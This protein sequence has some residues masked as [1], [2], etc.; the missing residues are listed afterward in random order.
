[1]E[2]KH[3]YKNIIKAISLFGGVK[4]FQILVG[5][6]KNKVVAVILG[7]SGMGIVGM[8]TSTTSMI[9]AL[10]GF[11]LETSAVRDVS[12]AYT[13]NNEESVNKVITVLRKLILITGILGM[14]ITFI[15]SSYLSVWAFGNTDYSLSFKIVS[16][17]LL[18]NQLSIGQ[19]V[20]LQGTFHYKYMAKA[21]FI[22]SILGLII[23]VPLYYIYEYQAIVPVIIVTALLNLILTWF[24]S[25]KIQFVPIKMSFSQ[26]FFEGKSMLI[27]GGA[28]ALTGLI[29][30][31]QVY[32]F[33]ILISNYGGM[34]D[35][36]LYTAGITIATSYIGI[37]LNAMGSD[38]SPR[39]ASVA[40]E[41]PL[42]IQT[43]NR[44]ALLL[45]IILAP[46]IMVFVVF[47]K[48]FVILLYSNKFV[49]ISDMIIWM[50]FGMFFRAISWSISYSFVAVN[51]PKLFLW[52]EII[53]TLYSLAFSIL[54]YL[55]Y[56]FTG[57]GIAF[58]LTYVLYSFHMY[59]L[60]KSKFGFYFNIDIIKKG[61]P[62]LIISSV[63]FFILL[64]IHNNVL[65]YVFGGISILI[66]S[67]YSLKNL[68]KLIDLRLQLNSLRKKINKSTNE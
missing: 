55:W 19:T 56:R 48:E 30:T 67:F 49:D 9:S 60:A 6:V 59:L 23:S 16:V 14:I 10:T 37:V 1:M 2:D 5:I 32:I 33:R 28:I 51:K 53:S 54:G 7:P 42:L 31:G 17:I 36:G 52:N 40:T 41:Q 24:F 45:M 68:N 38:Y 27:L 57:L 11:G 35:V 46:L 61:L 20:L 18:F 43:I 50:M 62:I 15:F 34:A 4:V 3:S 64:Y 8:I 22:G 66:I 21:S 65:H 13:S 12:Q 25:L 44:Q 29:N 58:C 26:I 39:L 63:A 47:I